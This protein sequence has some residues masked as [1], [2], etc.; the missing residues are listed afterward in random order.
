[1]IASF[2]NL[3]D[4]ADRDKRAVCAFTCYDLET[5]TAVLTAASREQQPVILLISEGAFLA[6]GGDLLAV[7]LVACARRADAP[8]CVQLDHT[9]DL[10]VVKAAF[11][12]GVQA[13]MVDGS[14]LPFEENVRLVRAGLLI[15]QRHEGHVEGELG[16]IGGE[17]DHLEETRSTGLTS[18]IRAADFVNETGVACLAVAIGNS[19]G[20]YRTT[21]DLRLDLLNQIARRTN[22]PLSLHGASGLDPDSIRRAVSSGI[23][24]LNVNTDLRHAYLAASESALPRVSNSLDL[25]TLHQDQITAVASVARKRIAI[26]SGPMTSAPS[27][28]SG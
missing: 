20:H 18:P 15:A 26:A 4:H 13:V 1:M 7:S 23:T 8:C 27:H 14:H 25:R 17:E 12:L 9:A 19:H 21:P 28:D 2:E 3:L 16:Q 5:A 6:G 22:K 11:E 24:K 10:D